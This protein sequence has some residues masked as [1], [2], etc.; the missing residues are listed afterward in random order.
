MN[1]RRSTLALTAVLTAGVVLATGSP[2]IATAAPTPASEAVGATSAVRNGATID[3]RVVGPSGQPAAGALV[4]AKQQVTGGYQTAVTTGADGSYHVVGLPSGLYLLTGRLGT[5]GIGK[6]WKTR[7][8]AQ[9]SFGSAT[10]QQLSTR[11]LHTSYDAV[12]RLRAP[13]ERVPTTRL[14]I[15]GAVVRL[16]G[17]ASGAVAEQRMPE[18]LDGQQQVELSVPSGD[19]RVEVITTGVELAPT[20]HLWFTAAGTLTDDEAEAAVVT[21]RFGVATTLDAAVTAPA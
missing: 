14:M 6:T 8:V 21:V 17:T 13:Y 20:E 18:I 12:V 10:H 4:I 19:Y 11:M 5:T 2:G 7:V 3:G 16:V 15:A 1:R 9:S